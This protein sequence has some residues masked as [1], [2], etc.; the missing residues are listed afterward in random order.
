LSNNQELK[1]INSDVLEHIN[2]QR[3]TVQK[4]KMFCV[5]YNSDDEKPEI[6]YASKASRFN[7]QP[8]SNYYMNKLK[9]TKHD[10]RKTARCKCSKRLI[11]KDGYEGFAIL[12]NE[13]IILIG[14][15]KFRFTYDADLIEILKVCT[16]ESLAKMNGIVEKESHLKSSSEQQ[17]GINVLIDTIN[18]FESFSINGNCSLEDADHSNCL[19]EQNNINK[20]DLDGS[21]NLNFC[22]TIVDNVSE[23]IE[24]NND[25]QTMEINASEKSDTEST[26]HWKTMNAM[27]SK[28]QSCFASDLIQEVEINESSEDGEII[29][30]EIVYEM[31]YAEADSCAPACINDQDWI[32]EEIVIGEDRNYNDNEAGHSVDL[33]L[34]STVGVPVSGCEDED[35][36]SEHMYCALSPS[37][38]ETIVISDDE[39]DNNETYDNSDH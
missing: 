8:L 13:S 1:K 25:I 37:Y 11:Q 38:D 30:E 17:N 2:N 6:Q 34:T 26:K 12:R 3:K 27:S 35:H 14:C 32:I 20:L 28:I 16:D 33:Q 5:T 19:K 7:Y 21:T 9:N 10:Y 22:N 15:M 18:N 23:K 4:G 31:N 29:E 39:D 36:K 24:H